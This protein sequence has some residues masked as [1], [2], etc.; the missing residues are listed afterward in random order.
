M[1][2]KKT[3]IPHPK[4]NLQHIFIKYHNVL[5]DSM[6][7]DIYAEKSMPVENIITIIDD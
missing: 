7:T 1:N 4:I 6:G 2:F 3:Q 5:N